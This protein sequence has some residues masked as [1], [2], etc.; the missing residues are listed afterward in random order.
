MDGDVTLLLNRW[1]A[2]DPAALDPIIARLYPDLKKLAEHRMYRERSDH[3]LQ[4]TALVSEFFLTIAQ[5]QGMLWNGRQHFLAVAGRVM[6]RMLVDY[7]RWHNAAKRGGSQLLMTIDGMEFPDRCTGVDMIEVDRA[8]DLL[9]KRDERAAKVVDM[10]CFSG[11][12]HREISSVIG[13]DERTVRRDWRFARA[14]LA[15]QLSAKAS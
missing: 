7:S 2:G 13:V 14:W 4:A 10:Y 8:L 3:T 12:T 15:T 11:L 6:R 1:S 9:A 5:N